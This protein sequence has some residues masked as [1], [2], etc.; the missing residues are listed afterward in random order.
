MICVFVSELRKA[1]ALELYKGVVISSDSTASCSLLDLLLQQDSTPTHLV[2]STVNFCP[3]SDSKLMFNLTQCI[4]VRTM[5]IVQCIADRSKQ[6]S[7]K[8]V[9][10]FITLASYLFVGASGNL[11]QRE[12]CVHFAVLRHCQRSAD[13]NRNC[14]NIEKN[15]SSLEQ[16]FLYFY[17][18]LHSWIQ[19]RS[20]CTCALITHLLCSLS[21]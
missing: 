17:L 20:T 1:D 21:I 7:C 15:H 2:Q 13:E 19:L 11:H 4:E 14:R 8:I 5:H 10:V 3:A 16:G 9:H 18:G 6:S 12:N